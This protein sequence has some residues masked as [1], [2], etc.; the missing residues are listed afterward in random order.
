MLNRRLINVV[1]LITLLSVFVNTLCFAQQAGTIEPG[2]LVDVLVRKGVLTPEQATALAAEPAPKQYEHLVTLLQQKGVL[3]AS[4]L[5]SAQPS[6]APAAPAPAPA[7]KVEAPKPTVI[8]AVAPLRVLQL[9]PAK[10]DGLIPDLKLGTGARIKVYGMVKASAIYDSSSPYG[11]DMPMPA[12]LNPTCDPGPNSS[13]FHLKAR[14]ARLGTAF[15]WPSAGKNTAITGK[16]EFDFEGNFTRAMNRNISTIRSSQASIR[17]AYGRIDHQ[18]TAKTS[19][20][21]LFGQDWTPFGSSTLPTLF[22]TT[23]MGL[24]F[25]TLYERAPQFRFGVGRKL[26]TSRNLFLQPEFAIVMPAEGLTPKV[27]DSQLG[28]GERQ[29]ADSGRPEVQARIVTQWQFDKAPGVAPAQIVFSGVQGERKAMVRASDVPAAFK[30]TFANGASLTSS[31]YGWSAELQLPTR[32]VTLLAKYWGGEDLRFYF[33]GSL[34]SVFTDLGGLTCPGAGTTFTSC[35]AP[36][37]DGSSNMIFGQRADGTLVLAPQR[38]VRSQGGF[39][40]LGFPLS[41]LF[42]ADPA[43]HNAG[44][45]LYLHYAYDEARASDVR[46]INNGPQ[47]NDLA[48]TTL[49]YRLNSLVSFTVEESYYRTR[50]VGDPA[51]VLPLPLFNGRPTRSWHDVRTEV[52]PTFTF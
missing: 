17:L 15:E 28:Y 42:K 7:P 2:K 1:F 32:Y 35:T 48:A 21:A 45:S 36:S 29:G 5:T 46:R 22:E 16:L 27:V 10:R 24:G 20:F 26:G 34:N 13:E 19:G 31:R 25:G 18:F 6:P 14:F 49:N 43:G 8:P 30:S 38:P 33:V 12:F 50:A 41:R 52:G 3:S 9:E 51:G 4:D 40:N 11:T 39:V 37:N 47:K 23:G 44:W